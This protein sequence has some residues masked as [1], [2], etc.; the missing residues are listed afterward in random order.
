MFKDNE[1]K[2][3]IIANEETKEILA[4]IDNEHNVINKEEILVIEDYSN[5]EKVIEEKDGKFYWKG[6]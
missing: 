3:I 5:N 6:E 2:A 4:M 1:L